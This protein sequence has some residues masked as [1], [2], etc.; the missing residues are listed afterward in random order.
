MPSDAAK[1]KNRCNTLTVM[2]GRA[3][4]SHNQEPE[5]EDP[6]RGDARQGLSPLLGTPITTTIMTS[7]T[8]GA[9]PSPAQAHRQIAIF[10][11]MGGKDAHSSSDNPVSTK[12]CNVMQWFRRRSGV[13]PAIKGLSSV[14]RQHRHR[15]GRER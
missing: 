7:A 15:Q 5:G 13:K 8:T 14:G 9:A 4:Q 10:P 11:S 1:E 3:V 6:Y 2:Y 12:A